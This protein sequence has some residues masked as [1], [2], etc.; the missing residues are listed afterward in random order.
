[1]DLLRIFKR[2]RRLQNKLEI[3][4]SLVENWERD[5]DGWKRLHDKCTTNYAA[6]LANAGQIVTEKIALNTK[7]DD[8]ERKCERQ[9]RTLAR[10]GRQ[11]YDLKH[12]LHA[13]HEELGKSEKELPAEPEPAKPASPTWSYIADVRPTKDAR[14]LMVVDRVTAQCE[15]YTCG[16]AIKRES[17]DAIARDLVELARQLTGVPVAWSDGVQAG[18]ATLPPDGWLD[19]IPDAFYTQFPVIVRTSPAGHGKV[20]LHRFDSLAEAERVTKI[21][22][23]T[24]EKWLPAP[25]KEYTL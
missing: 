20:T 18:L 5:G 10:Q 24:I 22:G 2:Y 17:P 7:A 23:L 15:W 25:P 11:I 14:F 13:L 8:L 21:H 19:F 1:M 12:S 6:L 4:Q 9:R 3:T 16:S